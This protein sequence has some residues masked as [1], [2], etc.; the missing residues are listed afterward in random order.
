MNIIPLDEKRVPVLSANDIELKAEE[1]IEFFN[2][3]VLNQPCKTPLEFIVEET[4]T[5]FKVVFDFE[6]DLGGDAP[7]RKTLG[8][9]I[10]SPR[11]ILIDKSLKD[12]IRFAFV[13]GHEFGHLVFHRKLIIKKKG[14]E[15]MD[16]S[17]TAKDLVTGKKIF[18]T[19]RDWL[20]W[21]A[22]RFSSALLMPR[23]TLKTAL[24]QIQERLNIRRNQGLVIVESAPYSKRDFENTLV[25]LQEVYGV[26]KRSIE[27]RLDD[28]GLLIDRR[29]KD[30]K[31]ISEIL[32]ERNLS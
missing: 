20:E 26:S 11:A 14:Y 7:N 32:M 21:Q 9:F 8:K 16:I 4:S 27:F 28:L 23:A 13:F 12:D 31:H 24:L 5:R 2:L 15:D 25:G 19:P 29:M 18:R 10:F 22:N 3:D 6:Q 30:T 1:V 17:D